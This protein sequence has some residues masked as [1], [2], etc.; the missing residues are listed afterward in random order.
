MFNKI[1]SLWLILLILTISIALFS[2]YTTL[3]GNRKITVNISKK[4]KEQGDRTSLTDIIFT[5]IMPEKG[6]KW[7]VDAEEV[8][9]SGKGESIV[10]RDFNMSFIS[11]DGD[12]LKLKGKEGKYI[13]KDGILDMKDDIHIWTETGYSLKTDK[14]IYKQREG[15]LSTD[16]I[17]TIEGPLL[18][19]KGRGLYCD[20]RNG[21]LR[22]GSGVT[23]YIKKEVLLR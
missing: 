9:I 17:V 2:I 14:L 13:K 10:F 18:R 11:K 1:K 20:C 19:I 8:G 23:T 15:I 21:Y 12:E 6:E 7:K 3:S 4:E 5:Q 16:N 22:I